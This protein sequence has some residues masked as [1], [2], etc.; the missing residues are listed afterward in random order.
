MSITTIMLGL[1]K[2]R[3]PV[4][5]RVTRVI[6]ADING[7]N[8]PDKRKPR[9]APDESYDHLR[10]ICDMARTNSITLYKSTMGSR[11]MT[12]EQLSR[13]L[14]KTFSACSSQLSRFRKQGLVIV[15]GGGTRNGDPYKYRW[16][17]N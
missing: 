12:A 8:Y 3:R 11:E 5:K 4:A 17:G 1:E 7:R 15:S 16:I 2:Y 10:S 6:Q 14:G 9:E 13:A